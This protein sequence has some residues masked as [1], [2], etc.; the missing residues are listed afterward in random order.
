MKPLTRHWAHL[1][2]GAALALAPL[3]TNAKVVF[4]ENFDYPTGNLYKCGSWTRYASN[5]NNPI[6]VGEGSLTFA[7]YSSQ[8][9]GNMVVVEKPSND[10]D[11]DLHCPFPDD[12][13]INTGSVYMGAIVNIKSVPTSEDSGCLSHF[14]LCFDS[15]TK[16]SPIADGKSTNN[17]WRLFVRESKNEGKFTFGLGKN[18]ATETVYTTTEYDLNTTYL[19][20]LKYEYVAGATNDV[21]SLYINEVGATEPATPAISTDSGTDATTS[22]NG[23]SSDYGIGGIAIMQNGT[24]AKP[25]AEFK[26]DALKVTTEW[27]ELFETTDNPDTPVT[28]ATAVIT[29]GTID[30]FGTTVPGYPFTKT[31]NVK[32]TGLTS[33]ITV[34]TPDN[35]FFTVSST[36]IDKDAA[37]S[38]DGYNLTI[39]FSPTAKG[40]FTGKFDLS[41]EGAETV[42][43][44]LTGKCLDCTDITTSTAI[45]NQKAGDGTTYRY[46]GKATVTYVDVPNTTIYAQDMLGGLAINY[47]L[48]N[49]NEV[50][51]G[52]QITNIVG[53]IESTQNVPY[54]YNI[55]PAII[56]SSDNVKLPTETTLSDILS[57]PESYIHRLVTV[58]DLTFT[59]ESGAK[60]ST[61]GVEVSDGTKTG[62]V[63]PFAGTDLIGT[64][65]PTQATVTGIVR[66]MAIASISPRSASDIVA[67]AAEPAFTVTSTY[68]YEGEPVA[69]NTPTVVRRYDVAATNLSAEASVYMT[70]TNRAM[71]GVT[72]E[73]IAKGSSNQVVEVTYTPTAIGK[74]TARVNFDVTPATL[75]AGESFTYYAYDP[76]NPPTITL[77]AAP[78]TLTAKP[79]ETATAT[80]AVNTANFVDY[81]SIKVKGDAAGVITINNTTLLKSG[82]TNVTITFK[83]TAEGEFTETL[84][85][86]ALKAETVEMTITAKCEGEKPEEPTQGDELKLTTENALKY[87]NETFSSVTKNQ[88]ISLTAWHNTAVTGKRAWWGYEFDDANKAAKVTAYDSK[89][90]AGEGT[91]CQMLLVTPPL[92]FV[93]APSKIVT[94]RVMGDLLLDGQTDNLEVCYMDIADNGNLYIQPLQGLGIPATADYNGTWQDYVI[95]FEGQE[96]ADVFFIGFRFTSTRGSDNSAV[97]YIDDVTYGRTDVP[98]IK[99]PNAQLEM[100]GIRSTEHEITVSVTGKNLTDNISVSVGGDNRD[101]FTLSSSTLPSTG[102]DLNVKFKSDELGE[103]YAYLVL[104]STGAASVSYPMYVNVDSESSASII[105]ADA[106]GVFNVYN[107]MG[108]KVKT[109][110]EASDL[111]RLP[112]G[113][114]I[115]NGQKLL[116]K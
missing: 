42:T 24:A 41:S 80:I 48:M 5:P 90:K 14:I 65:I 63:L 108:I 116:V 97:Y 71:F 25:G 33:D 51:V 6:L 38:A 21:L 8:G 104:S 49:S 102:G 16:A 34:G 86:S 60:F 9:I 28:P 50:K 11:E 70:G 103:Y 81:G 36:T 91:P 27:S 62:K 17:Y 76:A 114:Y 19:V 61:S 94:F 32:A 83:P 53:Y 68:K 58:A 93:N 78:A 56:N 23:N 37:M 31:L 99:L 12:E 79:G 18:K 45:I 89:V 39:T 3:P 69:I 82:T 52:D 35:S 73:T 92:D 85:F 105:V 107:L 101:L 29:P 87:L 111:S 77:P 30:D 40:D 98:Q 66:S 47:S 59:A 115:V 54:I 7:G 44:K 84:V 4:T 22:G 74:H 43:V 10:K 75:S 1:A 57:S 110:R 2:L 96:L 72:P 13:T 64:E 20:V 95:D 112:A 26:L 88:P 46:I 67:K 109:T 15:R 55:L 113:V 100:K 106:N